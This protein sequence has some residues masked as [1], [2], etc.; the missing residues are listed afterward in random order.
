M[1]FGYIDPGTGS[2]LLSAVLGG[3]AAIGV[4]AKMY[5]HR[6][7]VFLHIRKPRDADAGV[8]GGE[9]ARPPVERGAFQGAGEPAG[10]S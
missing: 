1:T 7:L 6:L 5:W 10:K 3:V 4:F 2:M 8:D 9:P